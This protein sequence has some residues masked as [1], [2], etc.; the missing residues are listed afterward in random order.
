MLKVMMAVLGEGDRWQY[1]ADTASEPT[2]KDV[3]KSG[4]S[5]TWCCLQTSLPTVPRTLLCC[6]NNWGELTAFV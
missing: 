6:L 1:W 2:L 5:D 4:C 3:T